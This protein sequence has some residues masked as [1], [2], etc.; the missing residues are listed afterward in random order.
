MKGTKLIRCDDCGAIFPDQDAIRIQVPVDD[1]PGGELWTLCPRCKGDS[2][3]TTD[4][5]LIWDRE[6]TRNY[7]EAWG[8]EY[9]EDDDE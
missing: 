9:E 1:L 5:V 7:C 4:D 8:L 6:W 3:V 2:L